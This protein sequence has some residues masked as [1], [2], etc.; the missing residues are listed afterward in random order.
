MTVREL[1]KRTPLRI[2]AIF[3]ALFAL[4]VVTMFATLYL[5]LGA[6]LERQIRERV[7]ETAD[8]LIA[9]DSDSGFESLVD[10]ITSESNSVRDSD[11]LFLLIDQSGRFRAGN[12]RDLPVF[13]G[14]R[15]IPRTELPPIADK[16]EDEDR[17]L[18]NWREVSKGKLLIG[19]SD[20]EVIETRKL[21]LRNLFWGLAIIAVLAIAA[22]TYLA[23]L[24]QMR[25]SALAKTLTAVSH[26]AVGSRVP[27]SASGDDLDQIGE[28]INRMLGH[29]QR[30]IENVNQASS[31]IAH[32]LK[33]PIGRLRQ[34]LDIALRS[35]RSP[36]DYREAIGAALEDLDSITDTFE[37]LLNIAQIEAGARKARFSELDL[38][39]VVADVADVYEP[40][41][42]DAGHTLVF[43]D[44]LK[45]PARVRGDRE[46]LTQLFANL[47]ENSIR[48]CPAATRI[49]LRLSEQDSSFVVRVDDTGPGIPASERENVFRRLYRLEHARSTPGSGLGLNLVAAIADLH[50]AKITLADNSPGLVVEIRFSRL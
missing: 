50:D 26:G 35:A 6:Q 31:D 48:H 20:R 36:E 16:G 28:Q 30:L 12:V 23:R 17:F 42:E 13:E 19:Y 37:A 46:L 25:I 40:V 5:R 8:A 33:K 34:R 45:Q 24:A 4:T 9:I 41:V 27:I 14:W 7:T 10:V 47:I 39:N 49:G 43:V 18:V 29:L 1:L 3:T 32:D 11:I 22:A 44:E 38:R 2:A 21:L 15:A